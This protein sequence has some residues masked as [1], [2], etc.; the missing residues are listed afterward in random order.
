MKIYI[1]LVIMM[2]IDYSMT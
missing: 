1:S 2:L